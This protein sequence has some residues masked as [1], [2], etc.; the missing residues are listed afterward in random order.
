MVLYKGQALRVRLGTF[1]ALEARDKDAC[2][3]EYPILL[4]ATYI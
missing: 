3:W 1:V 4:Y 2:P